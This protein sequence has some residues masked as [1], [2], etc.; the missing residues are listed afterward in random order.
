MAK[1]RTPPTCANGGNHTPSPPGY[2]AW[3]DWAEEMS[4]TH[5]QKRCPGCGLYAVWVPK[6][7]RPDTTETP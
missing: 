6:D 3:H 1:R 2:L 5:D 4:K 7:P